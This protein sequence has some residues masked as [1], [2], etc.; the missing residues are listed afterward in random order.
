VQNELR[1]VKGNVE[2]EKRTP[3]NILCYASGKIIGTEGEKKQ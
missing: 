1:D 2:E 3:E